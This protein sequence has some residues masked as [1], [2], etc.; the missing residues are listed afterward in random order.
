VQYRRAVV[1]A[2]PAEGVAL[3]DESVVGDLTLRWMRVPA[4]GHAPVDVLLVSADR[5]LWLAATLVELHEDRDAMLE[6]LLDDEHWQRGAP[7]AAA[8]FGMPWETLSPA[9]LQAQMVLLDALEPETLMMLG[10]CGFEAVTRLRESNPQPSGM[11][12]A[13]R[14]MRS[15]M[16]STQ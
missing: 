12:R 14:L 5:K 11:V 13:L 1:S 7:V 10:R 8:A 4:E 3:M 15:H 6:E 2:L 9:V 16:A